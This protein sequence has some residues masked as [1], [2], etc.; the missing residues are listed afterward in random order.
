MS[1]TTT[2]RGPNGATSSALPSSTKHVPASRSKPPQPANL[3]FVVAGL[4]DPLSQPSSGISLQVQHR[5]G[6]WK[7]RPIVSRLHPSSC[8]SVARSPS[9]KAK[10]CKTFI[11][12]SI[13]PRAS[14]IYSQD[15][16]TTQTQRGKCHEQDSFGSARSQPRVQRRLR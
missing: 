15:R 8:H 9:G 14:K 5:A 7:G 3:V 13:P 11:G 4:L 6:N 2:A 12:G 1:A 10:V 16:G